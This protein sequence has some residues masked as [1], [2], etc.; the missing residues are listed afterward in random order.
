MDPSVPIYIEKTDVKREPWLLLGQ[1]QEN[2]Y[3]ADVDVSCGNWTYRAHRIVLYNRSQWFK[4][5]L[6]GQRTKEKANIFIQEW[7]A[8]YINRLMTYIYHGDCEASGRYDF[9]GMIE[10]WR[11]GEYFLMP[12]LCEDALEN[13]KKRL[14]EAGDELLSLEDDANPG[15][16]GATMDSS[17]AKASAQI[18]EILG[19]YRAALA[20]VYQGVL[21]PASKATEAPIVPPV[22]FTASHPIRQLLVSFYMRSGFQYRRDSRRGLGTY[23]HQELPEFTADVQQK[24]RDVVGDTWLLGG[25]DECPLCGGDA[26]PEPDRE[27]YDM[28]GQH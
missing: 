16:S 19:G 2:N 23:I 18:T 6:D 11:L 20:Y 12:M 21:S 28:Y 5:A 4:V 1:L 26:D 22:V 7:S 27:D 17:A 13:L 8:E 3:Y 10:L 14:D 25:P 9:A 15:V 24:L